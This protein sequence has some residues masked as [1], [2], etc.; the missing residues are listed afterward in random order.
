[1]TQKSRTHVEHLTPSGEK[2]ES[3]L[4]VQKSIK[5]EIKMYYFVTADHQGISSE[6][7][8]KGFNKCCVSNAVEGADYDMLWNGSEDDGNVRSECEEVEDT[9]CED[10]DSDTDW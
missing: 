6:V 4:G 7:T 3:A 8:L 2:T 9:D 1:V 5:Q 10:E